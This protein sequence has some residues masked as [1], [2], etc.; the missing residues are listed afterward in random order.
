M[1]IRPIKLPTTLPAIAPTLSRVLLEAVSAEPFE[2]VVGC[3]SVPVS[4]R[5]KVVNVFEMMIALLFPGSCEPTVLLVVS[6]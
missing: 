3:S 5:V 1:M 6:D 2:C 4:V